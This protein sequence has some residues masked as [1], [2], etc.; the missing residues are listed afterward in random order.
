MDVMTLNVLYMSKLT[1]VPLN[2]HS[3]YLSNDE[4]G[5]LLTDNI[6]ATLMAKEMHCDWFIKGHFKLS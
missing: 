1:L 5:D 6:I 3:Y 4:L 2:S